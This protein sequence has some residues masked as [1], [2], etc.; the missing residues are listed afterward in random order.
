M[1]LY[2]I[3]RYKPGEEKK[4]IKSL[5]TGYC[6]SIAFQNLKIKETYC[7]QFRKLIF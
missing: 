2:N 5:A 3:K 1:S 4:N 6:V 7:N